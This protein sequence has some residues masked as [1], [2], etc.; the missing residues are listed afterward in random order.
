[1]KQGLIGRMVVASAALALILGAAFTVLLFAITS[2]SAS[3]ELGRATQEELAAVDALERL[4]VDLETGLRGFVITREE[5]FLEPWADARSRFRAT[6]EQLQRLAADESLDAAQTQRIVHATDEYIRAYGEP[7]IAA[8]RADAAGARS[9]ESTDEGKE[10]TDA[11]RASFTRLKQVGRERLAAREA[12]AR[13]DARRATVVAVIGVGGSLLLIW[14]FTR[15]LSRVIVRP[16]LRVASAAGRLAGGDLGVRLADA[17]VGEIGELERAFNRMGDSLEADHEQVQR[18][19]DEQAALRRVATLVAQAAPS[20]EILAAVAAEVR[21]LFAADSVAIARR[22][23][24]GRVVMV[25]VDPNTD[26]MPVGVPLPL[27]EGTSI[28]K[29]LRT[30]RPVRTDEYADVSGPLGDAID[31]LG[32]RSSVGCPILVEDR[33]WGALAAGSRREPLGSETELR[34]TSFTELVATSIANAE[35]RS[36]LAASR[37][38]VVAAAD[39]TRRRIGRDLHDGAQQ[40]LV[41]LIIVLKLAQR[42]LRHERE[43]ADELVR[44]ALTQ[45]EQTQVELRELAHGILPSALTRSGLRAS[46]DT[47]LSR[48]SLRV[49]QDVTD[50]RFSPAIEATAYFVISESLTNVVKHAQADD[51]HVTVAVDGETLRIEVRDSGMGGAQFAGGTGLIGLQDRVA[52]VDGRLHLTSPP[53]GGTVVLA[54]LPISKARRTEAEPPPP[55]DGSE[56]A[57][58]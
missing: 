32:L 11:L 18:L 21:R 34:L 3:T 55:H 40:R 22:E 36:A 24:G 8:V 10:R 27:G 30:A 2:L 16:V 43:Q 1:M 26:D 39:D 25:A 38:R 51:A 48:T 49:T 28:A 57:G 53:G 33:L 23:A 7:L 6:A 42:V 35:H 46:V 15:Y 9:V 54:L 44:E 50:R 56:P 14:L 12:E 13:G 29:V 58:T 4:T 41:H 19:A 45:A 31:R 17:G 52:A 47:I 5:R 37:A 20:S